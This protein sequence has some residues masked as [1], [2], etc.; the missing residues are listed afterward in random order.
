V[1]N[2]AT[3]FRVAATGGIVANGQGAETIADGVASSSAPTAEV[4]SVMHVL[5]ADGGSN[6][7]DYDDMIARRAVAML[8]PDGIVARPRSRRRI[9]PPV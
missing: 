5:R 8:P 2:A 1:R 7:A 6:D 4:A 9:A 3:H